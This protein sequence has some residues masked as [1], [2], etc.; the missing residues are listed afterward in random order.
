MD[1]RAAGLLELTRV[2]T[3]AT[4]SADGRPHL[5]PVVFALDGMDVVTAVDGKPKKGKVL[6]RIKNI[7]RD[8]RVTLL[9]HIYEEEWSKLRWVRVDGRASVEEGGEAFSRA[10]NS[11]RDRYPQYESVD[12][13]GPVIRIIVENTT[14]WEATPG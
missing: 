1:Q 7:A 5:V 2:A 4:V 14:T 8:P 10:V 6:A 3:L 9:A 12:L 11:L 13:L